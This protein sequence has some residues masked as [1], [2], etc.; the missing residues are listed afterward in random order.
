MAG[1]WDKIVGRVFA[2][3]IERKAAEKVAADA[4]VR[5]ATERTA[6]AA[7]G[8]TG[9]S[10]VIETATAKAAQK[11]AP[12]FVSK[13]WNMG[14]EGG[15]GADTWLGGV[16]GKW[17]VRGPV[18]TARA[19]LGIGVAA[20][21]GINGVNPANWTVT[22]QILRDGTDIVTGQRAPVDIA[23]GHLTKG[24]QAL[25]QKRPDGAQAPVDKKALE[26]QQPRVSDLR[27]GLATGQRPG[28]QPY[29]PP[30]QTTRPL[31]PEEQARRDLA[32]R[33]AS[34]RRAAD[35]GAHATL[36]A[37]AGE[38]GRAEIIAKSTWGRYLAATKQDGSRQLVYE[39]GDQAGRRPAI[40]RG[41]NGA[42][43][44]VEPKGEAF[45]I[46]D[47][48]VLASPTG[49]KKVEIE[50]FRV[51]PDGTPG[52]KLDTIK[53]DEFPTGPERRSDVAPPATRR[54]PGVVPG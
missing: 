10:A 8:E 3:A 40:F 22:P 2:A 30:K 16:V 36:Y 18:K 28:V 11:S 4:T 15:Y 53:I 54:I 14:R 39:T 19:V 9:G 35:L 50:V 42:Q 48:G 51:Q 32:D 23:T 49:S 45:V 21:V 5:A 24:V 44:L 38:E 34:S 31:T 33:K 43:V 1:I 7:V 46:S 37:A 12:G 25:T 29:V 20:D 27:K 26:E 52:K 17:A 47:Q 13:V 6:T 41:T